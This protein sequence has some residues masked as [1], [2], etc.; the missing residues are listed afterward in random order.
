MKLNVIF[1]D[2]DG[3][4]NHHLWYEGADRDKEETSNERHLDPS[5]IELINQLCKDANC[6]VVISSTWRGGKSIKW[7]QDTLNSRGATFEVIDKTGRC[8]SDVRGVEVYNWWSKN[9]DDYNNY[10]IFDDDNDFLIEQINN[11]FQIDGYCGIT[12]TIIYKAER[13][14]NGNKGG[15]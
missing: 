14:L 5:K 12:P 1:L 11:F 6:K 3:V 4:L 9:E 10:V 15:Q 8:C 7:L 2:I 13:F